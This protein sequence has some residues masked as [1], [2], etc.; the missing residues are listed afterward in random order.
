M[1]EYISGIARTAIPAAMPKNGPK[2]DKAI[3]PAKN[4]KIMSSAKRVITESIR[5]S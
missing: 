2:F 4:A 1:Y 3:N 5:Q